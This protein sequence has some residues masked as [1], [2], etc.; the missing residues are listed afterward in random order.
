MR[1]KL[2]IDWQE[3]DGRLVG[4]CDD[5]GLLAPVIRGVP[6]SG[7]QTRFDII[8][9]GGWKNDRIFFNGI[10]MGRLGFYVTADLRN[11]QSVAPK[12]EGWIATD[13]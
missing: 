11:Y 7:G 5:P 1:R 3:K 12:M 2:R 8:C 10:D 6:K 4:D 13:R 9:P